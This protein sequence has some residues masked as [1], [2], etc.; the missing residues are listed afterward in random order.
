MQSTTVTS[1]IPSDSPEHIF[2]KVQ[3][4]L[5]TELVKQVGAT[6]LFVTTGKYKE[7]WLLDLKNGGGAVGPVA[8]KSAD[9]DVTLKMDSDDL[10]AMFSGKLSA[11]TAFMAGKLKIV[12]SMGHALALEKLMKRFKSKL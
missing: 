12:G 5:S 2:K 11:T 4:L 8:G 6:Y 1:E 7:S 3:P 10:T 9:V